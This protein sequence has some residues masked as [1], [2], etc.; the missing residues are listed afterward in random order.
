MSRDWDIHPDHIDP[1]TNRPYADYSSPAIDTSFHDAEMD[2]DDEPVD[3]LAA[4]LR[5]WKCP[6]CGGSKVYMQRGVGHPSEGQQIP[7]KVCQETGLHPKA[8]AAL[9]AAGLPLDLGE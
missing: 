8:R 2:V 3:V 6:S 5:A 9:E 4:G 7:C 1:E